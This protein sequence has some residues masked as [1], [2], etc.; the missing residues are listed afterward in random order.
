[1][2]AS[3]N[4]YGTTML[5]GAYYQGTPGNGHGTVFKLTPNGT[6][7]WTESILHSFNGTDGTWP[8]SG[9]ILDA[10]G[11]LYGTTPKHGLNYPNFTGYGTVFELSPPTKVGRA[12]TVS[13][14]LDM[15]GTDGD[16][17]AGVLTRDVGGNL[18]GT[19]SYGGANGKGTVFKLTKSGSTWT[20]T[21]L[22]SFLGGSDGSGPSKG[23]IFD[24]GGNLYGTTNSGG[25]WSVGTVFELTP[26]VG[27]WTESVLH[28]FAGATADGATPGALMLGGSG[29]LYGTTRSGGLSN[30]GTVFSLPASGGSDSVLYSFTGGADGSGPYDGVIADSSGN[31]F[32]TTHAGGA[33]GLGTAFEL[34]GNT[35]TTLYT[36]TGAD[37]NDPEAGLMMDSS[38]N[39]YGTT[40]LGGA[41]GHGTVFKLTNNGGTWTESVLY[42]FM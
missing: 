12:W 39:L 8:Q 1:M 6:G 24:S 25:I 23:V 4:L 15:N 3:G 35:L 40:A 41:N 11:N 5:G 16:S 14:L 28:P 30:A 2:D 26:N 21:V 9:L 20:P 36:F 7:G 38:G 32:G 13:A 29:N 33:S 17:P 10:N 18:Y 27:S 34:T 42:S 19:A 31:F 37:G 22:F